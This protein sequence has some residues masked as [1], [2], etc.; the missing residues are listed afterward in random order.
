MKRLHWTPAAAE[1]LESIGEYL[2]L[3]LPSL[4]HSTIQTIYQ[5]ILSLRSTPNR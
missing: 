4:A 2:A 3:H 5:A 1:D